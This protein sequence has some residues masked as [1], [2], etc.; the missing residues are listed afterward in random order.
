MA[1][2]A[3]ASAVVLSLLFWRGYRKLALGLLGIVLVGAVLVYYLDKRVDEEGRMRI[4]VSDIAVENVQFKRT[5][6]S[7]YD[8][9]GKVINNS[10]TFTLERMRFDVTILDCPAVSQADCAP[11]GTA[12]GEALVN[13]PPRQARNFTASLYYGPSES[14]LKGR[15][16][17]RYKLISVSA[18]R[19]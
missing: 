9:T 3:A 13:V 15:L 18:S 12:S 17:W 5:Y 6:R 16:D 1:W 8:L 10:E 14:K 4:T 19:H 2:L 11:I 7:S